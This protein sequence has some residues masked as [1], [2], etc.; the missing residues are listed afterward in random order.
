MALRVDVEEERLVVLHDAQASGIRAL[1]CGKV[2]RIGFRHAKRRPD[3]VVHADHNALALRF[4]RSRQGDGIDKIKRTIGAETCS[5]THRANQ[6][7]R[8]VAFDNQI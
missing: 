3:L 1:E 4:G 2:G 7:N 6:Y 8:L 5:G